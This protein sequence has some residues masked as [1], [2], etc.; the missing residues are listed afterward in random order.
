[1][2]NSGAGRLSGVAPTPGRRIPE[3]R[4][5]G[6]TPERRGASSDLWSGAPATAPTTKPRVGDRRVKP[7]RPVLRRRPPA[8]APV[9]P[10]PGT[11]FTR[12][13]LSLAKDT[14]ALDA[15]SEW[16]TK[17]ERCRSVTSPTEARRA[18]PSPYDPGEELLPLL[19]FG[20]QLVPVGLCFGLP[21]PIPPAATL[22]CGL[23]HDARSSQWS[24]RVF[25]PCSDLPSHLSGLPTRSGMAAS[26]PNLLSQPPRRVGT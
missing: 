11:A 18:S 17:T 14:S 4:R 13:N 16:T 24:G 25:R 22:L 21:G 1:M 19:R 20:S 10:P 5:G 6:G 12:R 26:I 3:G 23:R 7:P 15:S 9:L 8:P 2:S